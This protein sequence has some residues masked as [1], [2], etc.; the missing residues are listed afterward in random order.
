MTFN[1]LVKLIKESTQSP[2]ILV[3]EDNPG[4]QSLFKK[5]IPM[6]AGIS[7]ESIIVFDNA[8][9][10]IIYIGENYDRITHYSL[11]FDLAQGEKGTQVAEFLSQRG[12]NGDNVWIHSGNT[13]RREEFLAY[14]PAAHI[15]PSPANTE[16]IAN[17]IKAT[18]Y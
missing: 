16:A 15:T 18:L 5:T 7:Q 8:S 13:D 12:N 10:S 9:E 6:K 14:L 17:N 1:N 3:V 2:Y 4:L 11:D